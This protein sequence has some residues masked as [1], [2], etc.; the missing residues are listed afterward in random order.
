MASLTKDS[1]HQKPPAEIRDF[2]KWF[3]G[4][5]AGKCGS[6]AHIIDFRVDDV[7]QERPEDLALSGHISKDRIQESCSYLG[8]WIIQEAEMSDI[9]DAPIYECRRVPGQQA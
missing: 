9:V 8:N 5:D 1:V 7:V 2:Y 6:D 3:Q 4:F